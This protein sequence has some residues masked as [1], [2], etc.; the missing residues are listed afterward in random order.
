ML[1]TF[2][3]G[4]LAGTLSM[5]VLA[6][7]VIGV[8]V[9]TLTGWGRLRGDTMVAIKA[10]AVLARI[11]IVVGAM[12]V[13]LLAFAAFTSDFIELDRPA[14]MSV[15]GLAADGAAC[16]DPTVDTGSSVYLCGTIVYGASRGAHLVLG[17]G[18]LLVAAASIAIGWCIY[19]AARRAALGTP[20]D[21]SVGRTFTVAGFVVLGAGVIGSILKQVAMNLA[22]QE[23]PGGSD[24]PF[25]LSLEYWPLL[26]SLGCFAMAAIFRHG[27]RLQRETEGLV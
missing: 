20:F 9:L 4:D 8:I 5:I 12:G 2:G 19:V 14:T 25:Y 17:V 15:D 3:G 10:T 21:R 7:V 18:N 1:T 22:V 16:T 6:L 26:V 24:V 27:A 13:I 23:L 11:W